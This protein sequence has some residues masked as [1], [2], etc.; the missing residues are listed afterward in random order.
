MLK[1]QTDMWKSFPSSPK[2]CAGVSLQH[3]QYYSLVPTAELL[4]YALVTF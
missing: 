2:K 1:L 4:A 3:F